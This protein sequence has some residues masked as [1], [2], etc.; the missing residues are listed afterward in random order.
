MAVRTIN[1]FGF[2]AGRG[3]DRETGPARDDEAISI[4][5]HATGDTLSVRAGGTE[6]Q[7]GGE[8]VRERQAEGPGPGPSGGRVTLGEVASLAGV[9]RAAASL[10]LRGKPGVAEG[11]RQ[12]ILEIAEELGYRVRPAGQQGVT[13]TIGLLV[14]ARPADIGSTNAFYAPVIAGVSRACAELELDLRLDSLSVDE[15]FNPIEVPRMVQ[16]PDIDGMII[17]GAFLS[18]PSVALLGAQP[19]VLVDGYG[20]RGTTLPSVVSDNTGGVASAT[21]HLIG[22]GHR[23]IAMVGTTPDAFPS[24]LE[25]R[26]GYVAAMAEAGL[27]PYLIDAPHEA[28]RLCADRVLRALAGDDPP[29][30][31]VAANDAIA[32]TVMSRAEVDVPG[33]VSL[34]GFDD[35]DAASLVR[36]RLSTVGVD[37]EAM[38]RLA[39]SLIR[40]RIARPADPAFT[41]VQQ[42]GL[43]L[44]GSVAPPRS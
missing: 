24:I 7:E 26:R 11:T 27:A 30:A 40:H 15:H 4:V 22:L 1:R 25:R 2:R 12:R 13:G 39:V 37:K 17:L 41:V 10:A 16:A 23:R 44:R 29:T 9:S 35:I 43:I 5:K 21:R 19:L 31:V 38:G 42:A 20:E 33:E 18:G 32:L 28:L 14:K 34:V 6:R 3:S 36:P 8:L